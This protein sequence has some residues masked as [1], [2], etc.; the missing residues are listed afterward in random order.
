M[1]A[2]VH[3]NVVVPPAWHGT[4][5]KTDHNNLNSGDIY[6]Q[7]TKVVGSYELVAQAVGESNLLLVEAEQ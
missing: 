5:I 7:E 6:V 1:S 2:E 3:F 4:N